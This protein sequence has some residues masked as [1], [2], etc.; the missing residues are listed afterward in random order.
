MALLPSSSPLHPS[1]LLLLLT[2]EQSGFQDPV[3]VADATDPTETLPP[4][5]ALPVFSYG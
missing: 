5:L 1:L 3:P 4:I 2:A